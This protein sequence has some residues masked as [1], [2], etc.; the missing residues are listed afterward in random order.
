MTYI[1]GASGHGSVILDIFHELKIHVDAFIDDSKTQSEFLGLKVLRMSRSLI[2]GSDVTFVAIGNNQIRKRIVES[3]NFKTINALHPQSII[4]TS[5]ILDS[6]VCVMP[7]SVINT[8]VKIGSHA[9]INTNASVDHDC[10]LSDY[11]HISPMA[12]LC[13]NVSV[14]EL[15]HIGAGSVILPNVKIGKNCIIGAGAVVIEDVPDNMIVVGNPA[16]IIKKNTT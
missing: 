13:G 2:K 15:S 8:N 16:R 10:F 14:G 7:G 5:V 6:G 9:I 11:V 12:T 3:F 1:Y 4:S